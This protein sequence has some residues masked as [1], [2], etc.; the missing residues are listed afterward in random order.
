[1]GKDKINCYPYAN[2]AGDESMSTNKFAL[3]AFLLLFLCQS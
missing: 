3:S 2:T 1:M